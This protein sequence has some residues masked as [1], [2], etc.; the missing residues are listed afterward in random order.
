MIKKFIIS[1]LI[2]WG[3][4]ALLPV[5]SSYPAVLSAISL[6]LF[7]VILVLLGYLV[8][9]L[10]YKPQR[11]PTVSGAWILSARHIVYLAIWLSAV[12]FTAML[13]DKIKIQGINYMDGLAFAREQWRV[14]GVERDGK[15][16][17]IWSAFG[18]LLGSSYYIALVL[19][20]VQPKSFR[21]SERIS[22]VCIIFFF[23]LANSIITGGR[24]NFMLLFAFTIA[25]FGARE[26]ASFRLLFPNWRQL[27]VILLLVFFALC[28]L[29]YIFISRAEASDLPI[30]WYVENFLP[31]MGLE[32][33][34]WYIKV[35]QI[36]WIA[37]IGHITI[38]LFGYLTHS[39]ATFAAILDHPT[40]DKI[41][42]FGN[43]A[44][45]LYKLGFTQN[46][47]TDWF[48][49]G[50]F[51]SVPGAIW[52]QFGLFGFIFFSF[53][54]GVVGFITTAWTS[55]LRG[56]RGL[57]PLGLYTMVAT[58]LLLT[59]YVF[60]PDFLNFTFVAISFII[61]SFMK[62]AHYFLK[63]SFSRRNYRPAF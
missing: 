16:S 31:Y 58:T 59:P 17:S 13:Y 4:I 7:F 45:L 3:M 40:E 8:P 26:G 28:Y 34:G 43:I 33:D 41:M 37:E 53:T 48:L 63:N 19:L 2:Y 50:R 10:V 47:D 54:L 52:H 42:I 32:F 51:P 30:S 57:L 60:A 6:Q 20:F 46:P 24:S 39:L 61:L 44:A 5:H 22:L 56:R 15:A 29:A 38:L 55:S 12:G 1:W 36:G 21:D 23:V 25:S 11:L 62:W 18:Y 27:R 35:S 9:S 14:I 49:A